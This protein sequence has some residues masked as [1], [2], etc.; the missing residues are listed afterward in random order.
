M[1]A[2]VSARARILGAARRRFAADG[3]YAATLEEVRRDAAVS[4]GAIYH[5][6]PDKE[7]LAEAVW[8]DALVRYQ[9][10]FLAALRASDGARAGIEASVEFHLRWVAAHRDDAALLF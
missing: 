6:F 8:L 7:Q 9:E 10:G 3:V 5:H 2:A 1:Y 4:V